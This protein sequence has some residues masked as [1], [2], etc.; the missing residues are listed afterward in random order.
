MIG[1]N[2]GQWFGTAGLVSRDEFEP[3]LKWDM[4]RE[5]RNPQYFM[6]GEM[7]VMNYGPLKKEAFDGI[8][9]ERRLLMRWPGTP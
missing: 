8:R 3:W 9:I 6:G 7:G 2:S 4:P 5:L 1:F